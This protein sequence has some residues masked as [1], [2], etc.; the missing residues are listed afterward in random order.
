MKKPLIVI[1]GPTAVGKTGT[2]I[3]VALR[4]NG[5]I[6]STDSMQIYKYMNIGTAKPTKEE[7]KGIK[8]H[9]IDVVAPD[10]D[11][12][13]A[14]FQRTA[15]ACIKQIQSKGKLPIA[16]GGTG[17]YINSL[18]YNMDFTETVSDPEL[19]E[20][21]KKLANERGNEHLFKMLERVDSE[22]ADRLHPNDVKRVIRALEVYH[23][24]GKPISY[25]HRQSRKTII[26]YNPIMIGLR[27]N[28]KDLYRRINER[29]D[30]MIEEGLVE[31]V[32][33][34]LA[35]GYSREMNSML[36][37]GYKEI[38]AYLEG[39]C[40]LEEAVEI[41]KRDTR[42]FAKRQFTWFRRDDRIFWIDIEKFHSIDELSDFMIEYIESRIKV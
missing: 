13:V 29:V 22:T 10:R 42:R 30:K 37:L 5:E 39:K 41:L 26:S 8:H 34:L 20:E 19:R 32:K 27:M 1:L 36:G 35:K 25:Y 18:V 4:L 23:C 2:S 3:R 15:R 12:T 6:I 9:M 40:S 21:L 14:D 33:V 17:L 11:F 24:S 7:M 28:R 31:E 38:I 16:V